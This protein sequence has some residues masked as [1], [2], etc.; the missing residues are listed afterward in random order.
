M[1]VSLNRLP[2][3]TF[4][5]TITIPWAEV[6]SHHDKLTSEFASEVEVKGFRK[7]KAPKKLAEEK[8]DKDKIFQEVIK[9]IVP[10]AYLKAIEEHHLH[11]IVNPKIELVSFKEE[12]DWTFK[13]TGCEKP[14]VNLDNYKEA[15]KAFTA[16]SKI[17]IPG[18]EPQPPKLEELLDIL[19]ESVKIEISDLLKESEVNRLLAK[20]LDEIK[21][22]GLTLEQYLSS[23]GKSPEQLRNEYAQKGERDLRLEFILDKIASDENITV[24]PEEIEDVIK[25]T[26]DKKSQES[27]RQN[28]YFLATMIRQ[29]KTLD[30][31]KNL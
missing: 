5:L 15:V 12:E 25:K 18:Q 23:V 1:V 30:F 28:S 8:I 7:G 17:I 4:E 16:K 14:E 3:S 10:D 19:A 21:A 9:Q 26:E 20:F 24:T 22:L 29:Q 2:K 11:P 27:L 13:A 31:V 6:K